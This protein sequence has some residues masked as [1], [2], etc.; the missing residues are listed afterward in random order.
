M[1]RS[2]FSKIQTQTIQQVVFKTTSKHIDSIHHSAKKC[3]REK[4]GAK[5]FCPTF[6]SALSGVLPQRCQGLLSPAV[7]RHIS[8][9]KHLLILWV[10]CQKFIVV[11][12]DGGNIDASD[13]VVID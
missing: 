7:I 4:S 8:I 6:D 13:P 10:S 11:A 3:K 12:G 2:S 1:S 9:V 5:G